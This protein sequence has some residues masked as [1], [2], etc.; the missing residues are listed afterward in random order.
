MI[1]SNL[2]QN[3]D[4]IWFYDGMSFVVRAHMESKRINYKLY[5]WIGVGSGCTYGLFLNWRWQTVFYIQYISGMICEI[6]DGVCSNLL[7]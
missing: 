6:D 7:L 3:T 4:S 1:Y 2:V 5:I